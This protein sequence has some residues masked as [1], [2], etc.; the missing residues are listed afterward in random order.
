[1]IIVFFSDLK[2]LVFHCSDYPLEYNIVQ[3]VIPTYRLVLIWSL[4]SFDKVLLLRCEVLKWHCFDSE[5]IV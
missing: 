2:L 5:K 3:Y 1:M 4:F